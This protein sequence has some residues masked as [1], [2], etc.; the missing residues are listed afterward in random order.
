MRL[1]WLLLFIPLSATAA[2]PSPW[3]KVHRCAERL[4]SGIGAARPDVRLARMQG[5]PSFS[6]VSAARAGVLIPQDDAKLLEIA[7]RRDAGL[8][9]SVSSTNV[10][11]ALDLYLGGGV[12]GEFADGREF[13]EFC[14]IEMRDALANGRGHDLADGLNLGESIF[15]LEQLLQL[16]GIAGRV[17]TRSIYAAQFAD[18]GVLSGQGPVQRRALWIGHFSRGPSAHAAVILD[19]DPETKTIVISDPNRPGEITSLHYRIETNPRGLDVL[20]LDSGFPHTRF[21]QYYQLTDVSEVRVVRRAVER[22]APPLT[23]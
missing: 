7:G 4:V 12:Q 9:S 2:E 10:V 20:M 19:L 22:V 23:P 18:L 15:A 16:R 13:A 3:E 14:M 1:I 8:C 17:E 21:T 5:S 11:L 6:Y